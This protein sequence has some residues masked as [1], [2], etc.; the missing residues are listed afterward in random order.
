MVGEDPGKV[1]TWIYEEPEAWVVE[2]CPTGD[3]LPWNA[4]DVPAIQALRRIVPRW[5]KIKSFVREAG[6]AMFAKYGLDPSDTLAISIRGTDK[7]TEAKMPTID[8]IF[9][10]IE[11]SR[12]GRRLWIKAEDVDAAGAMKNRYPDAVIMDDFFTAS[13]RSLMADLSCE[14]RG[15]RKAFDAT[16]LISMFARCSG[17]VK[18]PA[19]ISDLAAGLS[20]GDVTCVKAES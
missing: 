4:Q 12:H 19:N 10:A 9:S 13:N 16:L 14:F 2:Y 8:A 11:K 15:Y 5:L 7:H 20:T 6:D 17:L 1:P 18:N 3:Q